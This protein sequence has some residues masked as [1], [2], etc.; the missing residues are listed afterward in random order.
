MFV[1]LGRVTRARLAF[2]VLL[3]A[4]GLVER[5]RGAEDWSTAL[6]MA[7]L[8]QFAYQNDTQ[9]AREQLELMGFAKSE[10]RFLSTPRPV[11]DSAPDPFR[12]ANSTPPVLIRDPFLSGQPV[13]IE[14]I[15]L[16]AQAWV[17]VKRVD[18][19]RV[20]YVTYRGTETSPWSR[21][22]ADLLLPDADVTLD[23]IAGKRING[24]AHSGFLAT[25]NLVTADA[26][27]RDL[28]RQ[29]DVDVVVT[30]HSLGAAAGTLLAA[31]LV[32]DL[33]VDP[34]RIR[35]YAFAS[36][37]VGD[38]AFA[39]SFQQSGIELHRFERAGDIV[40][41]LP[42][43]IYS[44]AEP[45]GRRTAHIGTAVQLEGVDY[46]QRL[47]PFV[48]AVREAYL[49]LLADERGW[50]NLVNAAFGWPGSYKVYQLV[51]DAHAIQGYVGDVFLREVRD[52]SDG[53]AA[54]I[55]KPS[56]SE[57]LTGSSV[58]FEWGGGYRVQAYR[59]LVGLLNSPAA[60]HR[61]EHSPFETKAT[62]SGL[63][64][65]GGVVTVTLE[66]LIG[67]TW[68]SRSW[69]FHAP[70]GPAST[71]TPVIDRVSPS[72]F[73]GPTQLLVVTGSH[74]TSESALIFIKDGV[75]YPA[76]RD[77]MFVSSSELRYSVILGEESG[78]WT[79]IVRTGLATSRPFPIR[80]TGKASPD[81][82]GPDI[83][84]DPDPGS[85]VVTPSEPQLVLKG[86]VTDAGGV[87]RI[88]W[89]D[90]RGG[91][92]VLF[93]TTA[94]TTLVDYRAVIRLT[95]GITRITLASTDSAGNTSA[96]DVYVGQ[97]EPPPGALPPTVT[98]SPP[99]GAV[100]PGGTVQFRATV[101]DSHGAELPA[102]N[103]TWSVTGNGSI[104]QS[105]QYVGGTS[106]GT[107]VVTARFGD[108]PG[109]TGTAN[110]SVVVG[111]TISAVS[112]A[113]DARGISP[114]R[115]TFEWTLPGGIDTS[116]QTFRLG[117]S[118]LCDDLDVHGPLQT[119]TVRIGRILKPDTEYFWT[120]VL[121]D[122]SG[123]S[124]RGPVFR[125]RTGALVSPAVAIIA[126]TSSDRWTTSESSVDLRGFASDPSG[127]ARMFWAND[128]AGHGEPVGL[129]SWFVLGVNLF[130]GQN[131]IS[132]TALNQLGVSTIAQLVIERIAP[133]P[134]AYID[135]QDSAGAVAGQL[136]QRAVLRGRDAGP[137]GRVVAHHLGSQECHLRAPGLPEWLRIPAP[138][139][140]ACN[141]AG[142][143][144]RVLQRSHVARAATRPE[145]LARGRSLSGRDYREHRW[146]HGWGRCSLHAR[147]QP[148]ERVVA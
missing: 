29:G 68:H 122:L 87:T 3:V 126:P 67:T 22:V 90:D 61:S 70:G 42:L 48:S 109:R 108:A 89:R 135:P 94:R 32:N 125:F 8:A 37:R 124:F 19:R 101:R 143:L 115:P 123:Q 9:Q 59:L 98:V 71:A 52:P 33:G 119:S 144:L 7:Q 138:D 64:T 4:S 80:V 83:S 148:A 44:L 91:S 118:E 96:R 16:S 65:N 12:T 17:C 114:I 35:V 6:R 63:P 107:Y 72:S 79:V 74:F 27:F 31:K 106:L 28:I 69:Q 111:G 38:A 128:R 60:Y 82:T 53:Q 129:E 134:P 104:D 120:M 21:F 81:V 141:G 57:P 51:L 39:S 36:P 127:I 147:W 92:D 105:G 136:R 97:P 34:S 84:M 24:G 5:A 140:R 55:I 117:T 47:G 58:T 102:T 121:K 15:A 142:T 45:S 10:C 145:H 85:A 20:V 2:L 23:Q 103:V 66:S 18:L 78:D 76:K 95:P 75:E 113:P 13:S 88:E 99:A 50:L 14:P 25:A 130:L 131:V 43:F 41:H 146:G 137:V 49:A 86:R 132:I 116:S 100:S 56:K 54:S 93:A 139:S 46:R 133:V 30:G 1:G 40:P 110:V 26:Q 77:V 11:R 73:A 62:A 112:P